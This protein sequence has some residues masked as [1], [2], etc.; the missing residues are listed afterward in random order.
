MPIAKRWKFRAGFLMILAA[1]PSLAVSQE[2]PGSPGAVLEP[3]AIG[4]DRGLLEQPTIGE[5]EDPAVTAIRILGGVKRSVVRVYWKTE[6]GADHTPGFCVADGMFLSVRKTATVSEEVLIQ[7]ASDKHNGKVVL[8]DPSSGLVLIEG[9]QNAVPPAP[10]L[11]LGGSRDIYIGDTVFAVGLS[12][13]G[14]AERCVVGALIGRDR[15]LEGL[16]LPIAYL[17]PEVPEGLSVGGLPVLDADGVVVAVD[18]GIGLDDDG[19][20]FHALPVELAAKLITDLRDFGKREVAWLGVTFNT[21]TTT[22]KVVSVRRGSPGDRAN[23]LPGDV[24]IRF[25]GTRIDTLDDLADACYTLTPGHEI[26]VDL[27]RGVTRLQRK[28]RPISTSSKPLENG[29]GSTVAPA[30]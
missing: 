15:S 4:R 16:Q 28:L 26:E 27:L 21:G 3:A 6:Q 18:L 24:V 12:G 10:A 17:R 13:E 9:A 20:E 5:A 19:E 14:E 7:V 25:A 1:A 8:V 2:N 29:G 11:K 23:I 22:P 30:P